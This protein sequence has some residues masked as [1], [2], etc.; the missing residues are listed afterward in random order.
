MHGCVRRTVHSM[1]DQ[2]ICSAE[3]GEGVRAACSVQAWRS[4]QH[5]I[6]Q[7]PI[8]A[9]GR[10]SP[11]SKD[12]TQ[13]WR[14]PPVRARAKDKAWGSV[15]VREVGIR[16]SMPAGAVRACPMGGR[17]DALCR[18]ICYAS[19]GVRVKVRI[20]LR[21]LELGMRA[22][23]REIIARVS[24]TARLRKAEA[25][26][27]GQSQSQGRCQGNPNPNPNPHSQAPGRSISQRSTS[28][29]GQVQ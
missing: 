11:G 3:Y 1:M 8:Q 28:K 22:P 12:Q 27:Q 18:A 2:G 7:H 29:D 25:Q 15:T 14:H 16:L 21:A 5:R 24:L 23:C 17:W 4:A 26:G 9:M 20:S 6:A 10:S 13:R 19:V